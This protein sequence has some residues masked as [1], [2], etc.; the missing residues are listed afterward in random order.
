MPRALDKVADALDLETKKDM[1]GK[2][3]MMKAARPKPPTKKDPSIWNKLTPLEYQQLLDYCITDVEVERLVDKKLSNLIPPEQELW[4]LDQAINFR[5]VQLD[6]EL[7]ESAMKVFTEYEDY[8]IEDIKRFTK[9]EL[10]GASRIAAMTKWIAKKTGFSP[11]N[12][13]KGT[14]DLLLAQDIDPDVKKLLQARRTIGKTSVKKFF[15][16][17]DAAS[18]DKRIRDLFM[19]HGA[20]T[21]RWSGKLVQLQNLAKS[22]IKNV[23][24]AI[25]DIKADDW[26]ILV[27]KYADVGDAISACVRGAI[28]ARDGYDLIVAD[29]ASIEARLVLWCAEE[30]EALEDYRKGED[31]Y[32]KMA[33]AIYGKPTY[34]VDGEEEMEGVVYAEHFTKKNNPKERELGKAAQ[35]GCGFGMSAKKFFLTCQARGVEITESLAELAVQTY[36]RKYPKVV[37][38]WHAMERAAK[39]AIRTGE[40]VPCGKVMFGIKNDFLLM[41]LPSGRPLAYYKPSISESNQIHFYGT[42]ST[43]KQF[44]IQSTYGACLTENMVQA[45]ARDLLASAMLS[46]DKAGYPVVM[47]VHDE[48]VSEVPK[49]FG[50]VEEFNQIITA[51]PHWAKGLPLEAEGFRTE[52]Y[53]K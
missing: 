8:L 29:Y 15:A 50:S 35:L 26:R 2:R 38:M 1:V 21:G 10:D 43:T 18:D 25:E 17:R 31:L 42:N 49:W 16:M 7:V 36:R 13:Q 24:E 9:G 30:E 51:L 47:H 32:C 27:E 5:G 11:E 34:L 46:L 14:V 44:E 39:Q 12:L 3:V 22:K 41:V 37:K 52:R 28:V 6:I 45:I 40:V 33:D 48:I 53:R 19:F 20:G 4:F 23:D